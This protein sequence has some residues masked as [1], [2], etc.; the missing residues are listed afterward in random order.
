M[1]KELNKIMNE[2]VKKSDSNVI[3]RC[4]NKETEIIEKNQMEILELKST[5]TQME[6]KGD[7]VCCIKVLKPNRTLW[8]SWTRNP[9]CP[10]F[11]VCRKQ[12]LVPMTFPEFQWAV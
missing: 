11:L 10:P 3:V 2:E 9:F 1:L 12:I 4:I 5:I 6:K 8:S 7:L